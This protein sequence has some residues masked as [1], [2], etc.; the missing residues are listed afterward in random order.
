M[1]G[2]CS[3]ASYPRHGLIRIDESKP[4]LE[5]A[6]SALLNPVYFLLRKS[7]KIRFDIKINLRARGTIE[8]TP[9]Q[10]ERELAEWRQ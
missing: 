8:I 5:A 10:R 1:K 9:T 6:M 7:G 2:H 4:N 3:A